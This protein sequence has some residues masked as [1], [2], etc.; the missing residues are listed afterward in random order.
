MNRREIC[1]Y[2]C[3]FCGKEFRSPTEC[4]EHEKSHSEN[5]SNVTNDAIAERLRILSEV[6]DDYRVGYSILGM[7]LKN[8]KCLLSEAARRLRCLKD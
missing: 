1:I 4:E 6:A 5:Y 7:P 2:T 3:E 8:F